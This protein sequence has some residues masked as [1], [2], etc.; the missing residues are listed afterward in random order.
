M[1]LFGKIYRNPG[2]NYD[3]D[4]IVKN[5]LETGNMPNISS[6]GIAKQ[7]K[8]TIKMDTFTKLMKSMETVVRKYNES[9]NEIH[10]LRNRIHELE[11]ENVQT[12]SGISMDTANSSPISFMHSQYDNHQ[13]FEPHDN[14]TYF[15]DID[16]NMQSVPINTNFSPHSQFYFSPN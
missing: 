8:I 9:Q 14:F 3:G 10:S 1:D 5:L 7:D 4:H 12:S 16:C 6:L 15:P 13:C 11:N 2:K